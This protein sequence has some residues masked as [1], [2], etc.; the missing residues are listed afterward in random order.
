[1][2]ALY[3]A[4]RRA[5]VGRQIMP[6]A[7]S[8]AALFRVFRCGSGQRSRPTG[9]AGDAAAA[10][11]Q[12]YTAIVQTHTRICAAQSSVGRRRSTSRAPT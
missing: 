11:A 3:R 6:P 7:T 10:L 8:S 9:A 2:A 12:P 4:A 5:N 1:M